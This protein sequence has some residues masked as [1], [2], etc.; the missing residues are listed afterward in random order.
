MVVEHCVVPPLRVELLQGR[1]QL[2]VAGFH[3]ET[4]DGLERDAAVAGWT[5]RSGPAS[6]TATGAVSCVS[7]RPCFFFFFSLV[8]QA[9]CATCGFA[10][11]RACQD[12]FWVFQGFVFQKRPKTPQV[13]GKCGWP[14]GCLLENPVGVAATPPA[15]GDVPV[16]TERHTA[17]DRPAPPARSDAPTA[18]DAAASTWEE[19]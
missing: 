14:R 8:S 15:R 18:T 6:W 5:S 10:S 7:R 4:V 13:R 9:E 19:L 16:A 1:T 12:E 11:E 3:G 17:R 2:Q